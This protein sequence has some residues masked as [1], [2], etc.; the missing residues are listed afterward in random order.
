MV[1]GSSPRGPTISIAGDRIVMAQFRCGI[2][3]VFRCFSLA[4]LLVATTGCDRHDDLDSLR[5]EP[6]FIVP[7]AQRLARPGHRATLHIADTVA[8]MLHGEPAGDLSSLEDT[9]ESIAVY[10]ALR[11][12]GKKFGDAW[13]AEA[14]LKQ[15]LEVAVALAQSQ[16]AQ[17]VKIDTVELVLAHNFEPFEPDK[18]RVPIS[19]VN[20]GVTGLELRY[21]NRLFM[22]S[23]TRMLAENRSFNKYITALAKRWGLSDEQIVERVRFRSFEAEQFLIRVEPA[24]QIERMF[25]GNQVVRYRAVDRENVAAMAERLSE[26]V[27]QNLH[28]DGR[29]T[30]LYAPG[31][32][33]VP[34]RNNVLRQWMATVSLMQI[35]KQRGDADLVEVAER[36]MRYN[37]D[38]FYRVENDLGIIEYANKA[39]LGA[40]AIATIAIMSS[41]ERS[42]YAAE[43][44]ALLRTT[45]YLWR[46][47]GSF[48][49]FYKPAGRN[50]VQNFYP[51]ETLLAWAMLYSET[52]D[53]ALLEKIMQS[54]EYYR[55]WHL[56]NRNPAFIP[57][58]TRA[59][60]LVWQQ[61]GDAS[62]AAWIFEMNDW[63]LGMQGL[64]WPPDTDGRFYDPSRPFGPPHASSTAVYLEGLID[65]F[66]L[67]RELQDHERAE[68]YRVAIVRG[69]R[70]LMQ[71][72][73]ADDVD[74]FYVTEPERVR[75]GLR[76]TVYDNA[77]RVDNIQHTLMGLGK[78]LETF[79]E[80]DYAL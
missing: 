45:E 29:M 48:Q 61:T 72:E 78:I 5:V 6:Q 15:S 52:H 67:A 66:A 70:S 35:V 16:H 39:K 27:L 59:Y 13:A 47:D 38:N 53:A 8:Q 76:T 20:R 69:L 37:L 18:Y 17:S 62:I 79:A 74:M 22:L 23:P 50:D 80:S 51:G 21:R 1:R 77:I 34:D 14:T 60:Y 7:D 33:E 25:R 40:I 31:Q 24:V 75:G 68:R 12:K 26:W 43:E 63:L 30:Y 11:A 49:T 44:A 4:A 58:H 3:T 36:N 65:A 9:G 56:E 64:A 2:R 55:A 42:A 41:P 46:D 19:N 32:G 10:V 57:W 28:T 54:Y 73:F 71:L